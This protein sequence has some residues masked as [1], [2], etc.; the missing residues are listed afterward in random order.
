MATECTSAPRASLY[1][2]EFSVML[3]SNKDKSLGR[4]TRWKWKM[5]IEINYLS[6]CFFPTKAGL[7]H[8]AVLLDKAD[9]LDKHGLLNKSWVG[10]CVW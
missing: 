1:I 10:G 2:V 4:A 6:V 7:L 9:L 8:K 3:G 5:E